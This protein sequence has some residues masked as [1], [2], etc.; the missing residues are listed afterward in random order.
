MGLVGIELYL[1]ACRIAIAVLT[2]HAVPDGMEEHGMPQHSSIQ[3]VAPK[4]AASGCI[5]PMS[6]CCRYCC[7]CAVSVL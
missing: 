6:N 3:L 2:L 1:L 4:T 7:I 5:R